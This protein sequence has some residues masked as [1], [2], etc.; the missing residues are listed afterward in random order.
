M[1][2]RYISPAALCLALAITSCTYDFNDQPIVDRKLAVMWAPRASETM[3]SWDETL[4]YCRALKL[5][6][7][8]DWR[9]PTK[10]EL[11]SIVNPD[12]VGQTPASKGVPLYGPFSTPSEGY[13]F[14][15][16]LVPGHKNAPWIM[17][18]RNG[19]VFNGQGYRAFAR[20]VRDV[21]FTTEER[22]GILSKPDTIIA[23]GAV[24]I[25]LAALVVA[26]VQAF[27]IRKHN[28]LSVVPY[29]TFY[30]SYGAETVPFGVHLA[31][32]GVGPAILKRLDICLDGQPFSTATGHP[33]CMVWMKAGYNK[34]NVAF[35]FPEEDTALRVSEM[36]PLLTLDKGSESDRERSEF[37]EALKRVDLVVLY[38]SV[39]G[40]KKTV[41]LS[42]AV[43]QAGASTVA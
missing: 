43:R 33:W 1:T 40:D 28:R 8:S 26:I 5:A 35:H 4:S 20:C 13:L 15:G 27:Q 36:F 22:K 2:L 12:V 41:R 16:T 34:P 21:R 25:A 6:G 23:A 39:Y 31:N 37:S 11:E 38:E 30:I 10:I 24:S 7:Y 9:L 42:K 18:I 29:L 3:L 14:S 32:N 19:H 17:N